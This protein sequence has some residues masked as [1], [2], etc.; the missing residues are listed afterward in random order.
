MAKQARS[1][2]E[3]RFNDTNYKNNSQPRLMKHPVGLP[4]NLDNNLKSKSSL[5]QHMP[6][7]PQELINRIV[8]STFC[9]YP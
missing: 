1:H 8:V 2:H 4:V 6:K 5:I 7:K 9:Q 3:L